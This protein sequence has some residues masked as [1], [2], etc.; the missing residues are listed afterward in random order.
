M[1][2]SEQGTQDGT[3]IKKIHTGTCVIGGADRS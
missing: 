1:D 2:G 3:I